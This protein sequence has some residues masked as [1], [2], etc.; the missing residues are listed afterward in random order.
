MFQIKSLA[1]ALRLPSKKVLKDV[2][3]RH[4]KKLFYKHEDVWYQFSNPKDIIIPYGNAKLY[5]DKIGRKLEAP[6]NV[7]L[8]NFAHLNL[9]T[10]KVPIVAILGHF[11]HG[12]TTLID[13]YGGT[14]LVENESH[15]ITQ[16][17]RSRM[18]TLTPGGQRVTFVDTPGQEIF[19]RM[20]DYGASIADLAVLVI[21]ADDGV[22]LSPAIVQRS[23]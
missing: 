14:N 9:A 13:A 17:V 15:A 10:Q 1:T 8:L 22:S 12:K 2:V 18:L 16:V 7:N 11:N 20:R 23:L 6:A 19:Y 21:A 5:S 3:L 4:R